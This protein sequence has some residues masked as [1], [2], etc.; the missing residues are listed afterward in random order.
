MEEVNRITEEEFFMSV[1]FFTLDSTLVSHNKE[2][3]SNINDCLNSEA[4]VK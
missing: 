4:L 2:E 1:F 3:T